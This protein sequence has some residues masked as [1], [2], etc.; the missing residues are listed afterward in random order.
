MELHH[1][2]FYIWPN[3]NRRLDESEVHPEDT[4]SLRHLAQLDIKLEDSKLHPE[5]KE[6]TQGLIHTAQIIRLEDSEL[7]TED[8]DVLNI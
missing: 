2:V 3:W 4:Q 6:K 1:D 8:T 7:L 5:V